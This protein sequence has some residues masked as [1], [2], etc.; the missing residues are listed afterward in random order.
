MAAPMDCCIHIVSEEKS[1]VLPISENC[2][3]K[4]IECTKKWKHL[5]GI[6]RAVAEK[7]S[8]TFEECANLGGLGYHIQCYRRFTDK[9][10]I[11]RAV[12]RCAKL[13]NTIPDDVIATPPRKSARLSLTPCSAGLKQR[14]ASRRNRHVLPEQCII[15]KGEKYVKV[16]HSRTRRREALSRCEYESGNLNTNPQ[17][18]PE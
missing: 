8:E 6:Q 11:E 4:I 18:G 3:S 2:L 13:K 17:N 16:A 15:C 5:D 12:K 1:A 9:T 7:L 10:K 14:S